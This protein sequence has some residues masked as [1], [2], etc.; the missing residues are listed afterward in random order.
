VV[1]LRRVRKAHRGPADIVGINQADRHFAR[2]G[3]QMMLG[4]P[5]DEDND[6][7]RERNGLRDGRA[8]SRFVEP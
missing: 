4:P 5:T 3:H 2:S 1:D 8:S 6:S 7:V